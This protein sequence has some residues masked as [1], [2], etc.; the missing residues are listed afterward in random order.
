MRAARVIAAALALVSSGFPQGL[1]P[2]A[3]L[4]PAGDSWPTYNGDYFRTAL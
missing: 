1:D 2:A 3:M 4:K